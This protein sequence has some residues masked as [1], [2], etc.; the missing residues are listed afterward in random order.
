MATIPLLCNIC[1]KKPVFSDVSHLLTHIASKGHLSHYYKV[2]VRASTDAASRQLVEAYDKWYSEWNVEDLM[3]DRMNMKDKKKPRA[4]AVGNSICPPAQDWLHA[5]HAAVGSRA[6]SAAPSVFTKGQRNAINR[7]S[8]TGRSTPSYK[9]SPALDIVDPCLTESQ[10]K[11]ETEETPLPQH[12]RH[13]DAQRNILGPAYS[14]A[15]PSSY[16][17]ANGGQLPG[18]SYQRTI[19]GPYHV[20]R[21]TVVAEDAKENIPAPYRLGAP[22]RQTYDDPV[23][24]SS[25]SGAK[26]PTSAD[27]EDPIDLS[28]NDTSKLKGVLWPGMSIFDSATPSSRRRR[29]QKKDN[30]ILEQL[31]ANSLDVEPTEMVWTPEGSFKKQKPITGMVDSS[32]SPWKSSPIKQPRIALSELNIPRPYFG[33]AQLSRPST[34]MNDRAENALLYDD[35]PD[36]IRSRNK[37][38]RGLQIWQDND[39]DD[40]GEEDDG[41][42]IVFSKRTGLNLLTRGFDQDG[43]NC[44]RRATETNHGTTLNLPDDP[45]VSHTQR[46]EIPQPQP[47]TQD[48]AFNPFALPRGPNQ[49]YGVP[50]LPS[51]GSHNVLHAM[52]NT[53]HHGYGMDSGGENN[54]RPAARSIWPNRS[55]ANANGQPYGMATVGCENSRERGVRI[56]WS[57]SSTA[58]ANGQTYGYGSTFQPQPPSQL[59]H[60]RTHSRSMS[61]A[62]AYAQLDPPIAPTTMLNNVTSSINFPANAMNLSNQTWGHQPRASQDFHSLFAAQGFWG[63]GTFNPSG[64][65]PL[66][67]ATNGGDDNANSTAGQVDSQFAAQT[68][69]NGNLALGNFRDIDGINALTDAAELT[70]Y[71][72]VSVND[73]NVT[74]KV[75]GDAVCRRLHCPECLLRDCRSKW[76]RTPA[77]ME[78]CL[79]TMTTRRAYPKAGPLQLLLP[80]IDEHPYGPFT[81]QWVKATC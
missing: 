60:A 19:Q 74:V 25:E 4:R 56:I 16:P 14:S 31:E 13:A 80:P 2:K 23:L 39:D 81:V 3:S 27:N 26:T 64:D 59:N 62:I 42:D 47:S 61:W 76:I 35:F 67:E 77:K 63:F 58:N 79:S 75:E 20:R 8:S 66:F 11:Y 54:S 51:N 36:N 40:Q 68:Q 49:M 53:N 24:I 15:Y 44:L 65:P 50:S 78:R 22:K 33:T 30:S 1:P 57:N 37:R 6:S 7:Q 17:Y 72:A 18:I 46:R 45:F 10:I 69:Q 9:P 34:Y 73:E 32:S 70:A 43:N 48:A 71:H 5:Y 38:K 52:T 55:T 21:D 12:H 29:N 28:P 41:S